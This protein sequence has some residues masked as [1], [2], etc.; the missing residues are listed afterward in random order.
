MNPDDSYFRIL[1]S[2]V[3]LY[4]FFTRNRNCN[5]IKLHLSILFYYKEMTKLTILF[6]VDI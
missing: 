4:I 6:Y 1:H 5:G 3:Y 2:V